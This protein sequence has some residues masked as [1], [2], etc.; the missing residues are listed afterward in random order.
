MLETENGECDAAI[1][2]L[3]LADL[4]AA[5]KGAEEG[6][7]EIEEYLDRAE[8]LLEARKYES[9]GYYAFVCDKCA[10][11]FTHYGRFFYGKELKARAEEIYERS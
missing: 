1:T 9:E 5:E 6:E 4:T 11:V 3:N 8:A 2:Y 7:K 10:P